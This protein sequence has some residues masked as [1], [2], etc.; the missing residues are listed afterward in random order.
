MAN[1]TGW[2]AGRLQGL[3][4]G[5]AGFT[6]SNFNSLAAG[7]C[8]A[9]AQVTNATALDL[10]ADLSFTFTVGGT[11]VANSYVALSLCML[12]QDGTTY[13]DGISAN[14]ATATP[15]VGTYQV[16]S[17]A[18]RSGQA[19][20]VAVY[21][22]FRNVLLPPGAFIWVITNQTTVALNAAAAAAV[23]MRTYDENLNI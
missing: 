3:T 5:S 19:S 4:W 11:T 10:Y 23:Q 15:P 8:V 18:I 14:A 1:T 16:S 2:V 7:S 20:G 22:N 17:C 6:A 9:S 13:G 12:N 21:G